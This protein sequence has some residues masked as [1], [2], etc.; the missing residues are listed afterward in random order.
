MYQ[1]AVIA[2]LLLNRFVKGSFRV[3]NF[4]RTFSDRTSD[5]QTDHITSVTTMR[6]DKITTIE[7]GHCCGTIVTER[8]LDNEDHD[9]M[10]W[11]QEVIGTGNVSNICFKCLGH[12]VWLMHSD[13]KFIS[14]AV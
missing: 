10:F 8:Y 12:T 4:E 7:H 2:F 1:N 6:E 9:I 14:N 5:P 3:E 11:T 13:S